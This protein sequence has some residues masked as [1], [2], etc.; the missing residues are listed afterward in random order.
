[1]QN[2]I[3]KIRAE[4]VPWKCPQL[5]T[6]PR[7]A[8]ERGRTT[9]KKGG[10]WGPICSKLVGSCRRSCDGRRFSRPSIPSPLFGSVPVRG[11]LHGGHRAKSRLTGTAPLKINKKSSPTRDR[12]ARR[13]RVARALHS[14]RPN[15]AP[16]GRR[17]YLACRPRGRSLTL[18][19]WCLW[20]TVALWAVGTH[21]HMGIAI[22]SHR[23]RSP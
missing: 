22:A 8:R 6:R 18:G 15:R 10:A 13:R 4:F 14:A 5:T 3:P 11:P 23:A 1:M 17:G 7:S 21:G 9:K 19:M 2:G 12:T 16:P 20:G